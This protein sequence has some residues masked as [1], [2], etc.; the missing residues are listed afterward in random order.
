MIESILSGLFLLLFLFLFG[1]VI[2]EFG[3]GGFLSGLWK[4]ICD[5]LGVIGQLIIFPILILLCIFITIILIKWIIWIIRNKKAN[6]TQIQ[7]FLGEFEKFVPDGQKHTV[8]LVRQFFTETI[9]EPPIP[10]PLDNKFAGN[11]TGRT[12]IYRNGDSNELIECI[13][14]LCLAE[15]GHA[16]CY[17]TD[18]DSSKLLYHEFNVWTLYDNQFITNPANYYGYGGIRC[19]DKISPYRYGFENNDKLILNRIEYDYHI[20]N[21]RIVYYKG[22][23]IVDAPAYRDVSELDVVLIKGK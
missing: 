10:G 17:Y 15:D 16:F 4:L 18:T 19:S 9:S 21:G 11:W 8:N 1:I 14:H 23:G 13:E 20:Y 22:G 12:H 2:R 6:S 3:I 5:F 7:N